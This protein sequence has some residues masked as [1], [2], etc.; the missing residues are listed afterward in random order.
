[1]KPDYPFRKTPTRTATLTL[2]IL[3]MLSSASQFSYAADSGQSFWKAIH[4][5]ATGVLLGERGPEVIDFFDP[6]CPYCHKLYAMLKPY[7]QA[8]DVRVLMVPVGIL[9]P[10]SMGKAEAVLAAND[11]AKALIR[12]ESNTRNGSVDVTLTGAITRKTFMA[13]QAN[14]GLFQGADREGVLPFLVIR[15]HAGQVAGMI[16]LPRSKTLHAAILASQ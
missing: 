11:P 2:A 15:T 4:Q 3:L 14:N 7:T 1:M 12:A 10:T 16:G 9:T 6:N 5:K 8:G 13:I